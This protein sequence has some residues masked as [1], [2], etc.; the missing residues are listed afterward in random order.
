MGGREFTEW[1]AYLQPDS[2]PSPETLTPNQQYAQMRR[3][4]G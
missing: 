1:L 4:L 2:K 3:V